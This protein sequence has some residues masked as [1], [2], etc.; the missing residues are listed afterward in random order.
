MYT[1]LTISD[2]SEKRRVVEY[3]FMP[4]YTYTD[5]DIDCVRSYLVAKLV[6]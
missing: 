2:T 5:T 6:Y 3:K 1:P 4:T